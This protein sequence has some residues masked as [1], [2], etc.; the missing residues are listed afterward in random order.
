MI[1]KQNI[2]LIKYRLLF[3]FFVGITYGQEINQ[4][5][6]LKIDNDKFVLQDK[7]YTSG[8]FIEYQKII[9]KDMLSLK[10]EDNS[11]N[12]RFT[13]GNETYTPENLN[14]TNVLFFDRPYAGWLFIKFEEQ[15][16]HNNQAHTFAI[17]TGITGEASLSGA[18]QRFWHSALSIKVPTW[19]QQ[20][21]FKWL[22]NIKS[23][24]VF[25]FDLNKNNSL[26]YMIEPSLG[27]KDIYLKNSLTYYL[28]LFNGLKNSSRIAAIDPS[29]TKEFYGLIGF[30]YKYV[31]H[32]TLI[33]GG[34][35]YQDTTYTTTIERHV[36]DA[37]LGLVY[38][39]KRNTFSLIYFFNTN[40]T[41]RAGDH[42]Y[43]SFKYTV[44]F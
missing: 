34:L 27:T 9:K 41:L 22:F 26:H 29:Q 25:N 2:S 1:T 32:N 21:G 23:K 14:S 37:K 5:F 6:S 7:Y 20:I 13:L 18:L 35:R 31:G 44:D 11:V 30:G 3:L 10:K 12:Y 36:L 28:G 42:S 15:V 19:T 24:H 43:G 17:E 38:K 8:L 40:E 39:N 33:Q 4:S 16:I